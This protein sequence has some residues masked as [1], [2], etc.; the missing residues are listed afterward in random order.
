M[1]NSAV[2]SVRQAQ[3]IML[4]LVIGLA[5][6]SSNAIAPVINKTPHRLIPPERVVQP[7]D[8][9][10]TISWQYGL[11]FLDIA[12][13]NGLKPPYDLKSGQ[14]L[15]L[16]P[17]ATPTPA[18]RP[19]SIVSQPLPAEP[20]IQATK[21]AVKTAPKQTRGPAIV[22]PPL[23][24]PS[25]WQWPATGTLIAKFSRDNGVN[26]IRIAGQPGSPVLATEAGDV[27]YVGEGLL[28]YGKLI[29]V[30]H[31]KK[32]LSAYAHNRRI[33]VNEGQR[34]KAGQK[35]A[36]MGSSGTDKTMLHFE[37]RV[38]GKP[39]NPLKYLQG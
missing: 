38:N 28:G 27:V 3:C 14:R 37:I 13:W 19:S 12:K 32:Y 21:P 5:G 16:R 35:I 18:S 20:A 2:W 33:D 25:N 22:A 7:A 31:S 17:G 23:P 9:I 24:A 36:E 34:V 8:S 26:G 39:E 1:I 4:S 10:Y 11:N 30:K 15:G 29:I 6:C